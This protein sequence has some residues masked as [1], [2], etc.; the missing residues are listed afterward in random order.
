MCSGLRAETVPGRPAGCRRCSQ[1][2]SL[3]LETVS[4]YD[5]LFFF[6]DDRNRGVSGGQ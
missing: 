3:K 1:S 2:S 5:L 6:P 4:G